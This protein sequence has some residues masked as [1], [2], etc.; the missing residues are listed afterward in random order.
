MQ[1]LL[2]HVAIFVMN[3]SILVPCITYVVRVVPS[4]NYILCFYDLVIFIDYDQLLK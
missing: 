1:D 2:V 3:S 4:Y